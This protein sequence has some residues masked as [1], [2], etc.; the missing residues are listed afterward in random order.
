MANYSIQASGLDELQSRFT[1]IGSAALGV[2][3]MG[4]YDGAGI[5][6]DEVGSG[7]RGISTAPFKY[8]KAGE[9]RKP[10]PE[11]VAMLQTAAYG[12]AK[13]QKDGVSVN[14]RVGFQS[15]GYAPVK[16]NHMSNKSRTKYKL[17][18]GKVRQAK[19]TEGKG[20]S[21]KPIPVIANAINS[22]TSFMDKQPFFRKAVS[23]GSKKAQAAIESTV[24]AI[25]NDQNTYTT[26]TS[27]GKNYIK[28]N[29]AARRKPL[30]ARG[31]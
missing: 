15:S 6:A 3:A 7:I 8:A 19:S 18:N 16:W 14:T 28:F 22:G 11:E 24:S 1:E 31:R 5:M 9:K 17:Q 30:S 10:S 23:K 21:L 27:G 26:Y 4:V 25:L 29:P 20:G 2:A 13:F 12:I